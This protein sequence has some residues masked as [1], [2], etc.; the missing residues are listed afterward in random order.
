MC[1]KSGLLDGGHMMFCKTPRPQYWY[2]FSCLCISFTTVPDRNSSREEW[3][4][5]VYGM[6]GFCPSGWREVVE[7]LKP[8]WLGCVAELIT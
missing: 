2:F 4:A 7:R 8:L 3:L 1:R 6:R 5:V